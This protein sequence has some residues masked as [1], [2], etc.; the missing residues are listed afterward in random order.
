MTAQERLP[1]TIRLKNPL[2]QNLSWYV[3][4]QFSTPLIMTTSKETLELQP[5]VTR[6]LT[7]EVD[8]TNID[9]GTFIFAHVFASGGRLGMREATCGTYVLPLAIVGGPTIYYGGLALSVLFAVAGLWL[10]LHHADMSQP[11]VVSRSWWLRFL[12][13]LIALAVVTSIVS[14]WFFAVVLLIL[15]MLTLIVALVK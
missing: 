7:W 3:N 8:K 13:L 14:F 15:T 9:L 11:T 5:G 1:V 12:F 2:D 4:T 10:W 6:T